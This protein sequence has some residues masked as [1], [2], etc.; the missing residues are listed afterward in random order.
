MSGEELVDVSL[1]DA[2]LAGAQLSD[3]E[4]LEQV[5]LALRRPTRL[6]ATGGVRQTSS[7]RQRQTGVSNVWL[8]LRFA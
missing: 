5:L 3:D 4:N 8:C 7:N 2:R 6:N 1:D